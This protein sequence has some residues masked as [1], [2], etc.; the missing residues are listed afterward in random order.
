MSLYI[1]GYKDGHE[2]EESLGET[3]GRNRGDTSVMRLRPLGSIAQQEVQIPHSAVGR[4]S[5]N[6]WPT[7]AFSTQP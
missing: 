6:S 5:V 4:T 7:A 1:L 3:Q 2:E